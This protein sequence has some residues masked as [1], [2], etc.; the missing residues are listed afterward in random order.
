VLYPY[1]ASAQKNRMR[2]QF[3]VAMPAGFARREPSE[4]SQLQVECL[5]EPIEGARLEVVVRF[6]QVRRRRGA[7][8]GPADGWDETVERDVRAG[9]SQDHLLATLESGTQIVIQVPGGHRADPL[10]GTV[11]TSH[12]L[13][14]TLSVAARPVDSPYGL[15][16]LRVGVVNRTARRRRPR[17]GTRHCRSRWCRCMRC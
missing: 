7:Q 11:W 6:L 10:S 15:A 9:L 17:P 2:W 3:S 5:I 12:D 16:R 8:D 4:R 13:E 1:R 14:A